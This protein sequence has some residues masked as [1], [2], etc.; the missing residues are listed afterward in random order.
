VFV[1]FEGIHNVGK[2]TILESISKLYPLKRFE[3]RRSI[4]QLKDNSKVSN[5]TD[6]ALGTNC[7]VAWFAQFSNMLNTDIVFDRFHLSEF[8]YSQVMRDQKQ[9]DAFEKFDVI[10]K[11]LAAE[12]VKLVYLKNDLNVICR[13]TKQRNKYYQE[14]ESKKIQDLL[15]TSYNLSRLQKIELTTDKDVESLAKQIISWFEF[16]NMKEDK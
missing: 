12:D 4:P 8:A 10:D 2:T 11:K 13:R 3:G 6:Y 7:T 15:D 5:I 1:I 14:E 16:F 9:E